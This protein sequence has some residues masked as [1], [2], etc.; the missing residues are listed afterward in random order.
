[1]IP[2]LRTFITIPAAALLCAA[3]AAQTPPALLHTENGR[4]V[5]S[6][7]QWERQRRP[8]ILR[9]LSTEVYGVAPDTRAET[10]YEIIEEGIALGGTATRRQVR[11]TLRAAGMER[12]A[13]M[14]LYIPVG[15]EEPVPVIFGLN[16]NGNHATTSDPAVIVAGKSGS[17]ERAPRG[18]NARRWPYA[19]AVARGYAVATICKDDFYPDRRDG[20]EQSVLPMLYT[21]SGIPDSVRM[22]AVGAWSWGISRAIDCLETMPEIDTRRIMVIGHSRLGKTSLW[23]A[24]TDR[25]IAVAVSNDSGSTGAALARGKQGETVEK[26]NASF[27]YWFTDNYKRYNGR[28]EQMPFDQHM[29]LALV[30]PRPLYVASASR[31]DW[32][33]PRNEMRAAQMCGAVYSLYG[34]RPLTWQEDGLPAVNT[35]F[36]GGDVAYHLREGGH[37]IVLYDWERFMDFADKY[38]R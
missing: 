13:D 31:D 7:R 19:E 16:F 4:P 3:A 30:A 20:Y 14:L 22:K 23:A 34:L 27:P 10:R 32:A 17:P 37:D 26:I 21:G 1:M 12:S 6:V 15:A 5:R 11:I 24:A 38:F 28:E 36:I 29:L 2:S 18:G 8:E 25:R 9:M 33:D 35:P